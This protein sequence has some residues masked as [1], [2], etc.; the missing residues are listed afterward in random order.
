MEARQ[1]DLSEPS[2]EIILALPYVDAQVARSQLLDQFFHAT[3]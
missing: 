2:D 3:S 1:L